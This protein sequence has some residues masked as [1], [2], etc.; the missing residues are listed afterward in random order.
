MKKDVK[1]VTAVDIQNVRNMA[2]YT[3][4]GDGGATGLYGGK[5]LSKA[6]IQVSA[7]G[8]L[9]E[10][11]STLG[12]LIVHISDGE[13]ARFVESIQRDLY[14]VMAYL[15]SAPTDLGK[16]EN[17]IIQFEKRIDL[18]TEKLPPLKNFILPGGSIASC[19]AHLARVSCRRAERIIIRYFHK[20]AI[21][22][23][24]D[25]QV[26]LKYINRLSDLL[27]TYARVFNKEKDI[28]LEKP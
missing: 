1:N 2:I 22:E 7:Y 12:M 27:F 26:I 25:S 23:H 3:R 5:R 11:T 21:M 19:W 24:P 4:T 13:E 17:K 16:W 6:D 9:D 28:I 15:A 20:G 14:V 10:L 18:L 8:S